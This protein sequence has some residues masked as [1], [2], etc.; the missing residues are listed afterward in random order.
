MSRLNGF[1]HEVL[2]LDLSRH[3]PG[4]LAT[5][6]LADMGARVVKIES[7]AGDELRHIGPGDANGSGCYFNAVNAGKEVLT[8]DLKTPAGREQFLALVRRADVLVESF[9]PGVMERLGLGSAFLRGLRPGLIYCAL[10]GYG[11]GGPL[12]D[13]AGHDGNYLAVSG[14]L[15]AN[16]GSGP[17]LPFMPPVADTTG[18]LLALSA[19]LGALIQRERNGQGCDLDL[20]LADALMPLQTFQLAE[21]AA[22]GHI[23]QPEQALF[24]GGT[25]YYRVYATADQRHVMLG[26]FEPKFWRAF[27]LTAGRPGWV[28]RQNDPLPQTALI[29]EVQAFFSGLTQAQACASFE[30]AD[31]CLTP[32]HDLA[33]AVSSAHVRARGLVRRSADGTLQALF[34]VRVD[35]SA[36]AERPP[37]RG[38]TE[39]P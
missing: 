15:F 4:P 19:I 7:P 23:P 12:E 9:R 28:E 17:P 39:D 30:E 25:A 14:A 1:L 11:R 18:S 6:F 32:V 21:L 8:L 22:T 13:V 37:V 5:Q 38:F 35:G 33:E 26:A 10:S 24:N 29:A 27:C 3:L 16:G 36:P 2:V 20:A 34:P 31:C